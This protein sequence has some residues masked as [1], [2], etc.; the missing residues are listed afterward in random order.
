MKF[1]YLSGMFLAIAVM[2]APAWAQFTPDFSLIQEKEVADFLIPEGNRSALR[3]YIEQER[4]RACDANELRDVAVPCVTAD[5]VVTAFQPGTILPPDVTATKL[6]LE[7]SRMLDD[8]PAFTQYVYAAN[9]VYLI[10]QQTRRIVDVVTLPE[11]NA[12]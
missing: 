2:V 4:E 6:P 11:K 1:M 9:N 5:T 3:T 10:E 12:P 8:T 7:V